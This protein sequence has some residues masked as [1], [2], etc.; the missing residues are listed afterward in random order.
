VD[1][2][3]STQLDDERD[4]APDVDDAE[5]TASL[6]SNVHAYRTLYGR[7]YNSSAISDVQSWCVPRVEQGLGP[8]VLMCALW[9][10]D[11]QR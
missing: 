4:S 6:I 9:P 2:A 1:D 5:S 10:Q 7:T 3:A 11:T 8:L